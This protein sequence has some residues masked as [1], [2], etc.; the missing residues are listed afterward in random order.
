MRFVLGQQAGQQFFEYIVLHATH[1]AYGQAG[2]PAV[3][4]PFTQNSAP[5]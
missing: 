3:D 4:C 2:A 5:L 1:C